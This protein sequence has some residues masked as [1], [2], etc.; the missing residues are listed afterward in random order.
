MLN[1]KKIGLYTGILG[2]L[3]S[4]A[5][6]AI[7]GTAVSQSTTGANS[8]VISG[9]GN[10]VN[11]QSHSGFPSAEMIRAQRPDIS[12]QQYQ[13]IQPGMT[14]EEVLDIVKI[15]GKEA[16]SS[17]RV[18]IYTWGTEAYIYMTVTLVDGRVQSKSH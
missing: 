13:A 4:V 8:P 7:P 6:L 15:P 1:M 17:G 11:Y 18:Q 5:A 3:A 16:A 14:Y 12:D 10:T 2:A 9:N